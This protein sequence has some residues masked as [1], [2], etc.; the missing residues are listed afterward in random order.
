MGICLHNG[1]KKLLQLSYN[2][3]KGYNCEVDSYSAF[4][5]NGGFENTEME[6]ELDKNEIGKVY[7]V[8]IALDYCVFYSAMD[9]NRLG[10][11]FFRYGCKTLPADPYGV[12]STR[13]QVHPL[14]WVVWT[15][16]FYPKK[17]HIK[18]YFYFFELTRSCFL[19]GRIEAFFDK[20][21]RI[22]DFDFSG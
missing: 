17:L 3:L 6:E 4:F 1:S 22:T 9:A 18:I 13:T 15:K 21:L 7:V 10:K 2:F 16:S 8:G 5:N 12:S 14:G 20:L 11:D 19:A